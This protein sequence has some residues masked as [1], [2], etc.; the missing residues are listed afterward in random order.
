M[1]NGLG[2]VIV[3][4]VIGGQAHSMA[5]KARTLRDSSVTTVPVHTVQSTVHY[6]AKQ[7]LIN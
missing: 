1:W 6:N 2:I 4:E 7:T 3:G 5:K